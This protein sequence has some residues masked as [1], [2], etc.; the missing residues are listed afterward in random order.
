M[1]LD[2]HNLCV[3]CVF[4]VRYSSGAGKGR[5]LKFHGGPLVLPNFCDAHSCP[6]G[7]GGDYLARSAK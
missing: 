3:L 7:R 2:V 4:A 5:K 6:Q 1:V